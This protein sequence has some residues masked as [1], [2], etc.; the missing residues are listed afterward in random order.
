MSTQDVATK[1]VAKTE[2]AES[3]KAT[4]Q[5]VNVA[6]LNGNKT[7]FD[8]ALQ[9]VIKGFIPSADERIKNA[10]NFMLLTNKFAHLKRKNE[11]L[12]RFKISSDGTKE[13]I[14]LENSEGFK[15]SVSNSK[16]VDETLQLLQT[17]LDELL[18]F[19]EKEVQEFIV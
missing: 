13:T 15:F 14:Y 18:S 1:K 7:K 11:E 4:A 5:L 17:K 8:E 9:K 6:E 3:P 10:E 19:T 12:K 16:V 2:K